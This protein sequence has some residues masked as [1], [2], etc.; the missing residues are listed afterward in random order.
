MKTSVVR[1]YRM[2]CMDDNSRFTQTRLHLICILDTSHTFFECPVVGTGLDT[3]GFKGEHAVFY[4]IVK[5]YSIIG[6]W[7]KSETSGS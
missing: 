2:P 1:I 4:G 3:A 5:G 7:K 6:E